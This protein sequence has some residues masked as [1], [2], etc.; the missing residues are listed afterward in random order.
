MITSELKQIQQKCLVI[1]DIVV[2]IC[3][4]HNI[5]YSLCGG[6]VVGAHIYKGF[7]PWDDDID[8]MMTRENYNRFLEV[9]PTSLPEGYS[10]INFQNSDYSTTLEISFTKIIDNNTT[11]VQENGD[12]IGVFVDI[13]VYDKVPEGILKHLDI[14]LCKRL[15]TINTGKK[16]GNNI[17]N[18]FRNLCLDTVLSNR[19]KYLMLFQKVVEL[20]GK[21]SRNYT[22]RELFGA[23][24][25]YNMIPYAPHIFEHYTTI[26]FEGREVMIVRDYIDYLQTRFNRVDFHEPEDKQIPSHFSYVNL[27]MPYKEYLRAKESL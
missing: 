14:F 13:D 27:N 25:G 24:H 3:Q 11:L 6:S 12:V 9:A 8:I 26:E 21:Y 1:F 23:Y 5:I 19:R 22:Y 10:I 17:K 18:R 20:L 4:E 16:P 7:L 15:L 2:K